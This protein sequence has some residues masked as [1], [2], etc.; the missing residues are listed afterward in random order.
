METSP[1]LGE[2]YSR[3][4]LPAV[5]LYCPGKEA[6]PRDAEVVRPHPPLYAG[7]FNNRKL[8]GA[9]YWESLDRNN[10]EDEK[11]RLGLHY[12]KERNPRC[13][14]CEREDRACMSLL[15]KKYKTTGCAFCIR[16][17]FPCSQANSVQ[18]SA[19]S[20][21][22]NKDSPVRDAFRPS[23]H[24]HKRA[25]SN[26]SNREG[27]EPPAKRT[28]ASLNGKAFE[29]LQLF[30]HDDGESDVEG[31]NDEY[32][33]PMVSRRGSIYTLDSSNQ[34][35][36]DSY[37]DPVMLGEEP[38]VVAGDPAQLA[39]SRKPDSQSQQTTSVRE[40]SF[41]RNRNEADRRGVS[42]SHWQDIQ[43][44]LVAMEETM[45]TSR[46]QAQQELGSTAMKAFDSRILKL[47]REKAGLGASSLEEGIKRLESMVEK[48]RRE[49]RFLASKFEAKNNSLSHDV[50]VLQ[51]E[52]E[53]LRERLNKLTG[54]V[55]SVAEDRASYRSKEAK[56]QSS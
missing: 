25:L 13:E 56:A 21:Q 1:E 48:E 39:S 43:S 24:A 40:R 33:T 34:G 23:G 35:S 28:R 41:P 14:L 36:E 30:A 29:F 55:R 38:Q 9:Y 12:G 5:R 19:T 6:I 54:K 22:K 32:S 7:D 53:G 4:H 27:T 10:P 18:K 50:A 3:S 17:H 8:K 26:V 15:G 52:N 49:R 51:G 37:R 42:R 45:S 46:Q 20:L 31:N 11:L 2:Q 16:R 47:E 44:R